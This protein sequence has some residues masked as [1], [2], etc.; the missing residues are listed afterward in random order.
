MNMKQVTVKLLVN[1]AVMGL[2]MKNIKSSLVLNI[3]FLNN[4]FEIN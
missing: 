4:Y 3:H 1:A 2:C